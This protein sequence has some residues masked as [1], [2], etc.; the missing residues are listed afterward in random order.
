MSDLFVVLFGIVGI[1]LVILIDKDVTWRVKK[2]SNKYL[3]SEKL[4]Y[5][6]SFIGFLFFIL[7]AT[8]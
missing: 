7:G 1:I 3:L 8:L 5:I 2:E 4:I 6:L